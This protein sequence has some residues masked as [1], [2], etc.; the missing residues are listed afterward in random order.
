MFDQIFFPTDGSD[1][2]TVAFDHVLDN[3]R[4]TAR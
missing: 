3:E 4:G 1:G 2:A